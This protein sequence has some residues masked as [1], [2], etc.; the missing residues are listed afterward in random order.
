MLNHQIMRITFLCFLLFCFDIT[1]SQDVLTIDDA[2]QIALSENFDIKVAELEQKAQQMQVYKSNAGMGPTV[3][4]NANLG[5]TGNRVNQLFIDGRVVNRFGRAISPSTNVSVG[6]ALIDGGRAKAIYSQLGLLSQFSVLEGKVIIQNTIVN[7]LQ[8]YYDISRHQQ[9]LSYLETVIKYYEERLKITEQRW[10]VGRGSKLD[11]L[12]SQ[13]ELNAQLS[14]KVRAK[15]SLKNAKVLLNGILNR[16]L[17]IDFQIE[18]IATFKSDYDLSV[19]QDQVK[20]KNRDLILM[21]KSMDINLKREEELE[22]AL[23]PQVDLR[24]NLGYSY[25]NTNAGFLL[26]NQNLSL[27]IN[28]SA[29]YRI[30]DGQNRKNQIS[31]AKVNT[32]IIE[33]QKENAEIQILTDLM[34]SFNQFT[35][36]KE[37]LSFEEENQKVAE[38]NLSISLDKFRLGGSTILELNEAQRTYD[39]SLNRLVNAKYNIK[40]SE[41]ELLRI[42]GSLVD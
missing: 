32:S 7:V 22:A 12:Q 18:E 20:L 6:I 3:D 39:A 24:A 36:D 1:F 29:R 14:E 26:S 13:T 37:L 17:N 8:A 40:I 28:V 41:L 30:F 38:E 27:P 16:D 19:L 9:T 42:T 10:Q 23:K 34:L 11:F 4:W 25:N 5:V 15:N 35:S 31:I 2:I 21:Q 33:I